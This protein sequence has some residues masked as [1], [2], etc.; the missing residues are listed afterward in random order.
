M[1]GLG[2]AFLVIILGVILMPF[3]TVSTGARGVVLEMSAFKGKVLDPG[4][5]WR[6]P[7]VQDVVEVNV[8]TQAYT[9]DGALAYTKDGQTVSLRS[10]LQYNIDPSAVGELYQNIG[11]SYETK[12][13]RPVMEEAIKAELA[14]YTAQ[15]I[16]KN[17]GPISDAIEAKLRSEMGK[18]YLLVTNY[19]LDN[20]DYD[21]AYE[22]AIRDKQVE[23]QNALKA[24][25]VTAQKEELKRQQILEAE[26][27]AEKTRLE[28]EALRTGGDEYVRKLNAEAAKIQAE[29]MLEFAKHPVTPT[30]L[31]VINGEGGVAT[32]IPFLPLK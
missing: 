24:K 28:V 22:A 1:F 3:T 32:P 21:D 2:V 8:Q 30:T 26:A 25:N 18:S 9:L 7:M 19:T 31:T 6:T 14:K 13:I 4:F 15:E 12:I 29:A 16:P 20:E 10:T 5:H 11:L 27:L 23:E 17:R